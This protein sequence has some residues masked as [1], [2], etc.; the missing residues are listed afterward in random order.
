MNSS[1][2]LTKRGLERRLKRHFLKATHSYFAACAPGF[3]EVLAA[4]I[5]QLPDTANLEL[6]RGGVSFESNLDALYH[7]NLKLRTAHRVL[8]RIDTFLAQSYPMLFNAA[9]KIPWE[10]YL[11]FNESYSVKVSAKTSRLRH[12]KNIARTLH[13][14]VLARVEPLGLK[15]VQKEDDTSLEFHI[16]FFQDRCTI[17]LNTSGEHLHKRGYRQLVSEAPIRETL[18]A[19]ILL[20]SKALDYQTIVDPMCGSGTLLIEGLELAMHKAAG[21]LRQFAF[22]QLPAFQPSK[23]ERFKH[24]A[25]A[26]EQATSQR[27][28][29]RDIEAKNI[30]IARQNALQAGHTKIDFQVGDATSFLLDVKPEQTLI[31]SNLPYG[32]RLESVSSLDILLASFAQ[33]LKTNYQGCHFAFICKEIDWLQKA[34]ISV[35]ETL[36]LTNGGLKVQLVQ[37]TIQGNPWGL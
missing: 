11:G 2:T 13:D 7:S 14:A 18:A 31:I 33:H 8:L 24:E 27:F 30:T 34:K 1:G 9:K 26:Q 3:E 29:G 35:L 20:T 10:L 16:R 25:K 6:E 37:G 4:E 36:S 5:A 12:H 23:W 21:R 15:P 22:E 17:S 32:E 28:I 19:S